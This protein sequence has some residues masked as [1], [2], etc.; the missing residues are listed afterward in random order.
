MI[1]KCHRRTD[2]RTEDLGPTVASPRSAL[3]LLS[4]CRLYSLFL[5]VTVQCITATAVLIGVHLDGQQCYAQN[6]KNV[7]IH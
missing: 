1:R 5:A 4:L 3:A 7:K 2:R 6:K